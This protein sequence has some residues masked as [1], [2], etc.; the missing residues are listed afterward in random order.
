MKNA[1]QKRHARYSP[2]PAAFADATLAAAV[3]DA[4]TE[5]HRRAASKAQRAAVRMIARGE[6]TL[7]PYSDAELE[8][9]S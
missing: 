9:A 1:I 2:I 7:T 5:A 8:V 4:R 6:L 3:R